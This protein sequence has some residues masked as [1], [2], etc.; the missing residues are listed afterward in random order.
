VTETVV[1]TRP[2]KKITTA[3]DRSSNTQL[4]DDVAVVVSVRPRGALAFARVDGPGDSFC[5]IY[6]MT[7][8]QKALLLR[9]AEKTAQSLPRAAACRCWLADWQRRCFASLGRATVRAVASRASLAAASL[10]VCRNATTQRKCSRVNNN[11]TKIGTPYCIDTDL[12]LMFEHISLQTKQNHFFT[13]VINLSAD[14]LGPVVDN[15]S[16]KKKK[17]KKKRSINKA[18][19]KRAF[20][21]RDL[22]APGG[23]VGSGFFVFC[24]K[25]FT[26]TILRYPK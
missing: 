11:E 3:Y 10:T 8:Y 25:C 23:N 14:A 7:S 1:I 9:F 24:N 6:T 5:C 17:K 19:A 18:Y 26:I 16:I 20:L 4:L 13:L 22:L 2:K 21:L 15:C 12:P